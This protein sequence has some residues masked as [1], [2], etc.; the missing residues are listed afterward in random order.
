MILKK[1]H[2]NINLINKAINEIKRLSPK[3][4]FST[5]IYCIF[6]S[7]YPFISMCFLSFIV[8]E[9]SGN[10]N[11]RLITIYVIAALLMNSIVFLIKEIFSGINKYGFDMLYGKEL[12]SVTNKLI[13]SDYE[14]I[15]NTE[16][17]S[18]IAKHNETLN[19]SGGALTILTHIISAFFSGILSIAISII[20]LL[21]FFKTLFLKNGM[22]FIEKPIFCIFI[23]VVMLLCS[24]MI[25]F[26]S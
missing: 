15:D 14:S 8:S 6:D 11:L 5:S 26:I 21:P 22:T 12:N 18:V 17:Q 25:F 16:Y 10:A 13:E 9:L 19:Q 3:L 7:L 2:K 20:I 23:I 1:V 24:L 4:L